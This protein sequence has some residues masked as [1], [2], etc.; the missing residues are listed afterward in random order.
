MLSFLRKG[1]A[2]YF[3]HDAEL[4]N[5]KW[6]F[7]GGESEDP[8]HNKAVEVVD[9]AKILT[10]MKESNLKALIYTQFLDR[11]F[12]N[13]SYLDPKHTR[14]QFTSYVATMAERHARAD[15]MR[16][17][18]ARVMEE[19]KRYV[20]P[21]KPIMFY[22]ISPFNSQ[23]EQSTHIDYIIYPIGQCPD[24][25]W[26][27]IHSAYLYKARPSL[28]K[29]GQVRW[30]HTAREKLGAAVEIDKNG[31]AKRVDLEPKAAEQMRNETTKL[32]QKLNKENEELGLNAPGQRARHNQ[33]RADRTKTWKTEEEMQADADAMR[34]KFNIK[35]FITNYFQ[36][37]RAQVQAEQI[38]LMFAAQASFL[39]KKLG[40]FSMSQ[41]EFAVR[42]EFEMMRFDVTDVQ[43]E[44]A[45]NRIAANKPK[46]LQPVTSQL[47]TTTEQIEL[48]KTAIGEMEGHASRPVSVIPQW[49]WKKL[50]REMPTK[51]QKE[52]IDAAKPFCG[53]ESIVEEG[54][55]PRTYEALAYVV[56]GY[57]LDSR[58]VIGVGASEEAR[59]AL[60]H[61]VGIQNTFSVEEL[62]A[63]TSPPSL[64]ARHLKAASVD[65]GYNPFKA[66]P[67]AIMHTLMTGEPAIKLT[68]KD[69]V[70]INA[71]DA[72]SIGRIAPLMKRVKE[73]HCKL[74][75]LEARAPWHEH[76][77]SL[78]NVQ[79]NRDLIAT[80]KQQQEQK[81][82]HRNE[83][84]HGHSH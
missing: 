27:A 41:L 34:K 70:I 57:Q 12:D 44:A 37:R 71:S 49:A 10:E 7:L 15:I 33:W 63:L 36:Q 6:L 5:L 4:G 3:W 67:K 23:G 39:G 20:V 29:M 64:K 14:G 58:K 84:D 24:G 56:I 81:Q 72:I 77:P 50:F 75:L 31:M 40:V 55:T 1:E 46:W 8:R 45:N 60:K 47:Y 61:K 28:G 82:R 38:D 30:A 78:S 48:H 18:F 68:E 53:S 51:E 74:I 62:I 11:S 25:K 19:G 16:N 17:L 43:I 66:I 79:W 32:S 9:F 83:N 2:S 26:R 59:K 76:T 13:A 65:H 42:T 21:V 69:V 73:A 35:E 52:R 22:T 54:A 80:N